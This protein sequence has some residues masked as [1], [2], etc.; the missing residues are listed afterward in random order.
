MRRSK[1]VV[2]LALVL[3]AGAMGCADQ[4]TP[5]DASRV[6]V[7]G[8]PLLAKS[9]KHAGAIVGH[10]AC[11]PASFNAVLG[12]GSCVKNGG[13][14]FD[15]FIGELSETQT[16]RAWKFSPLDATVR[17]GENM[18]ANNVGGEVHTFTPV[19][20]Y[21]GGFIPDLNGIS[22]NPVPA[23]EC[24]DFATMVF[25]PSGGKAIIPG[26]ALAAVADADGIARVECCLHPWMR[27]DVRLR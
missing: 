4:L 1:T 19:R 13:T 22:G 24:L 16:A 26:A 15:A 17:A 2:G 25:V 10:D 8:S 23:P 3:A 14:T 9:E 21:G 5:T 7:P 18:L 27:T 20:Q 12:D 11:D 6:A